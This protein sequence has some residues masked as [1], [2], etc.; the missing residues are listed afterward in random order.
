M[1]VAVVQPF[2][3]SLAAVS[4]AGT[5]NGTSDSGADTE[6]RA[7]C[8]YFRDRSFAAGK[9]TSGTLKPRTYAASRD[10]YGNA[11]ES[12]LPAAHLI[13]WSAPTT[14]S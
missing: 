5:R 14:S 3:S 9:P 1:N 4:R 6:A 10:D 2:R 7:P 13:A 12:G 11:L 8:G